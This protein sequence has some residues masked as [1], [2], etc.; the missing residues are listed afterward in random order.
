MKVAVEVA[1]RTVSGRLFQRE[2]DKTQTPP[3]GGTTDCRCCIFEATN[4]I[5]MNTSV[6]QLQLGDEPLIS[7]HEPH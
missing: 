4:F 6:Y 5:L 3:E 2:R 7:L 1:E